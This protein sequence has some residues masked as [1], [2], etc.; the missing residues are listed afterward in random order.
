MSAWQYAWQLGI[1]WA[2]LISIFY[3]DISI[4]NDDTDG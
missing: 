3:P 4:E 2:L 1:T